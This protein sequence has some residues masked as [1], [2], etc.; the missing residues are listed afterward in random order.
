MGLI[1]NETFTLSIA[2]SQTLAKKKGH[3][4]LDQHKTFR[5]IHM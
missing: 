1:N 2:K 3:L 4:T 5:Y